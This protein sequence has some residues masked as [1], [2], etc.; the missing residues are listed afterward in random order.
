M[1]VTISL[2]DPATG[3]FTGECRSGPS[4]EHLLSR[5]PAGLAA[6]EGEFDHMSKRVA[7]P[8][9]GE[10]VDWQPPQPDADHEWNDQ[11]RRWM[12]KPEV[13]AR[14]TR[15]GEALQAAREIERDRQARRMRELMIEL[16]DD[17]ALREIE[18]QIE[19]LRPDLRAPT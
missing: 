18:A 14:E 11:R 12:K 19:A 6:V 16:T 3:A 8:K 7:D 15:R 9:T 4:R 13:E 2:Y 10:V 1:N 17:P 5:L